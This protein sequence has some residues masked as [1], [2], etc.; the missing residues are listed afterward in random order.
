VKQ[1]LNNSVSQH[2]ISMSAL[3]ANVCCSKPLANYSMRK[4]KMIIFTA[5]YSLL[6]LNLVNT[7]GTH[8]FTRS[9]MSHDLNTQEMSGINSKEF[10]ELDLD[11][12][13]YLMWA[14]NAKL[15]LTSMSLSHTI[16]QPAA[17]T[18]GPSAAKKAKVLLFLRHHL[19]S[20]LKIEYLTEE[21]PLTLWQSLKDRYD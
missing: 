15:S 11:G 10:T 1:V 8:L 20:T 9:N 21:D 7:H 16:S 3:G 4:S 14:M 18:N 2:V 19:N 12:G 5:A 6:V 17:G 13:N